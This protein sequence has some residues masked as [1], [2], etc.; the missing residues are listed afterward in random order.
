MHVQ[1]LLTWCFPQAMNSS[2]PKLPPAALLDLLAA[3]GPLDAAGQLAVGQCR[4][5]RL[6]TR[7]MTQ[8]EVTQMA[9]ELYREKL[10]KELPAA[11]PTMVSDLVAQLLD[12][13]DK[14]GPLQYRPDDILVVCETAHEADESGANFD[15]RKLQA[16]V[17]KDLARRTKSVAARSRRNPHGEAPRV[18]KP[19]RHVP[20]FATRLSEHSGRV[21]DLPTEAPPLP[22]K[23]EA[24]RL[25]PPRGPAAPLESPRRP[26][27]C[28]VVATPRGVPAAELRANLAMCRDVTVNSP[29]SPSPARRV[30]FKPLQPIPRK[31]PEP[32][33]HARLN[34]SLNSFNN[35]LIWE[36]SGRGTAGS[37]QGKVAKSK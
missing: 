24:D 37:L 5:G 13:E 28:A 29:R 23:R 9:A 1:A 11:G 12:L 7:Q 33:L 20:T 4:G 21:S 16:C 10:K 26:P 30:H 36:G 15:F 25:L 18:A 31:V 17:S 32:P 19:V 2:G 34:T 27:A 35:S 14:D 8:Q 3:Y 22:G 6:E